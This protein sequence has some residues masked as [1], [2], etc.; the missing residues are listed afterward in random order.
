MKRAHIVYAHPEPNSFV[1]AMRDFTTQALESKGWK[2]SVTDLQ[3][4]NFE[5]VASS[6]DFG[7]RARSDYLVYPLEQRHGYEHK[8]LAPD[9]LSEVEA[10]RNADLLVMVF[11]V[12]WYSV[13]A[14][15]KGWIDRV[16]LSGAFYGG[17]RV[18]DRG[19]MKGKHAMVVASLG[20]RDYM[21]EPGSI[22]GD[23]KGMMRHLLQGTLGYVGYSVY[24]PFFAYHAP[25]VDNDVRVSMLMRLYYE[26]EK[27]ESRPVMPMP[28]L[29]D[30]DDQFRPKSKPVSST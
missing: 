28:S 17:T 6:S 2:T 4:I 1:A 26:I 30:F 27:L 22:H 23:L 5:P 3:E 14:Q 20:G 7:T 18:Y 9:I 25:Y 12:F 16:F 8:T 10:V 11:P 13:P 21:F 29:E 24:D 19:G 15:M